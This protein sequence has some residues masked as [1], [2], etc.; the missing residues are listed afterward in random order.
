MRS[1]YQFVGASD[2]GPVN[3]GGDLSQRQKAETCRQAALEHHSKLVDDVITIE[4]TMG[5]NIR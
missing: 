2:T 1:D 5:I 4:V 3:Y